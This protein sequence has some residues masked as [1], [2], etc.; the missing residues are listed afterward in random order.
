MRFKILSTSFWLHSVFFSTLNRF[1]SVAFAVL[2]YMLL[3]KKVFATA[4]EMGIWALFMSIITLVE[5]IKQ[6][7]L[8]NSTI[9]FLGE[10]EYANQKNKIQ[11]SSLL[12][13]IAFSLLIIL[14]II[15]GGRTI[16]RWLHTPQLY[17][18]CLWGIL[19]VIFLIPSSHCEVLMHANFRFREIFYVY[20]VK[21]AVF[22]FGI[23]IMLLFFRKYLSLVSLVFWQI[24]SA[25]CGALLAYYYARVHFIKGFVYDK[26]TIRRMF[27]FGKY[28]FGTNVFSALSRQ[29]DQ[30]IS[31]GLMSTE[32]TA[33][34]N[35][36][37][38]VNNFM[39]MPSMAVADVLFP[40]NVEAMA[41]SGTDKVRYYFE[42]LVGTIVSIIIPI[43]VIIFLFPGL[44]IRIL[45]GSKY[46]HAI[47]ILQTVILSSFMRPFF[48]QFGA[49]MDAIGRPRLN[50]WMN[51]VITIINSGLMYLGLRYLGWLGAAYGFVVGMFINFCI[52]L[53]IL[54]RTI[55]VKRSEIIL[56]VG[57]SYK[58]MFRIANKFL[59]KA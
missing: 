54:N 3:A 48:Y 38:R 15:F 33:Y 23:I 26:I 25:L 31:A 12:I 6:G 40:K 56:Y 17:E 22:L 53:I 51:L 20:V 43:S 4:S 16:S 39:D 24:L 21:Q 37:S 44:V 5:T 28:I 8:R 2:S 59:R 42:R 10:P 32:V 9:K 30:F 27:H 41:I 14:L 11:T 58:N 13:N 7:L 19:I 35:V 1:S 52:I 34:Y 57:E 36:S 55:G 49:T 50:F 29:A 45:A 46:L 18:L 47:P